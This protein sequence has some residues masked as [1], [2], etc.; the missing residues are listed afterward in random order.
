MTRIRSLSSTSSLLI[1]HAGGLFSCCQWYHHTRKIACDNI[2]WSCC[3]V[4]NAP[5][6]FI[7]FRFFILASEVVYASSERREKHTKLNTKFRLQSSKQ[8]AEPASHLL[9]CWKKKSF[10]F[11]PRAWQ[12]C[13]S[14]VQVHG[15]LISNSILS[16]EWKEGRLRHYPKLNTCVLL[17]KCSTRTVAEGFLLIVLIIKVRSVFPWIHFLR[18]ELIPVYFCEGS[19]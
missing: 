12:E 13:Q 11:P 17:K 8:V 18:T 5:V 15:H 3:I 19:I 2:P 7:L 6:R 4:S 14:Q 1:T 10:F 16:Q 9:F